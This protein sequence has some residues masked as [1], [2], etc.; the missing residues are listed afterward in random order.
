[1]A[2]RVRSRC[3]E[4]HVEAR[5]E[6]PAARRRRRDAGRVR[7]RHVEARGA[8]GRALG[9]RMAH[10]R[11]AGG[12]PPYSARPSGNAGAGISELPGDQLR[13]R[14]LLSKKAAADA[15]M[16]CRLFMTHLGRRLCIAVVETSL[17]RAGARSNRRPCHHK[18]LCRCRISMPSFYAARIHGSARGPSGFHSVPGWKRPKFK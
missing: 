7:S 4:A 15:D 16:V 8:R 12:P 1:V 13:P 11:S 5:G 6:G 17:I 10:D 2:L 3:I 18:Q 9:S 14:R